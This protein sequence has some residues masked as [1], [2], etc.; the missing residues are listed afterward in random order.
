MAGVPGDVEDDESIGRRQVDAQAAR[1]RGDD[2]EAEA[3]AGAVEPGLE[4][5]P[6]DGGEAAIDAFVVLAPAPGVA[7]HVGEVLDEGGHLKGLGLLQ[8]LEF[9][10]LLRAGVHFETL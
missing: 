8:L 3:L 5:V 6:L 7:V 4:G 1:L 10:R 9:L 2:E